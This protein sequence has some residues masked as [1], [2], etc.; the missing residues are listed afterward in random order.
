MDVPTTIRNTPALCTPAPGTDTN[1][2]T[3][4][5]ATAT[6][7]LRPRRSATSARSIPAHWPGEAK[8]VPSFA[9]GSE[10]PG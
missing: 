2:S 8:L 10:K 9:V 3:L 7:V 5:A 1:E 4:P 6:A